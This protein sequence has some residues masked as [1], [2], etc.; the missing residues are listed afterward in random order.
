M[1]CVFVS[2]RLVTHALISASTFIGIPRRDVER[3]KVGDV[4]KQYN[5]TFKSDNWGSR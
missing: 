3:I 4:E 5:C 2:F 1:V